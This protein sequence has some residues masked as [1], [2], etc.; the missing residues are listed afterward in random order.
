[1]LRGRELYICFWTLTIVLFAG[2]RV[3]RQIRGRGDSKIFG[4]IA[5]RMRSCRKAG[6]FFRATGHRVVF[7]EWKCS[8]PSARCIQY[9]SIVRESPKLTGNERAVYLSWKT[10]CNFK[11]YTIRLA[12]RIEPVV[13]LPTP[14]IKCRNINRSSYR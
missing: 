8:V 13:F 3:E 11:W 2:V 9:R 7:K 12:D 1:M 5:G 6:V 14:D 4:Q 10:V